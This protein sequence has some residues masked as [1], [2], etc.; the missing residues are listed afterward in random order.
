MSTY[1]IKITK[2]QPASSVHRK[3]LVENKE[4]PCISSGSTEPLRTSVQP[5]ISIL[6]PR[7]FTLHPGDSF[8]HLG[9][10]TP[11]VR[12]WP[13]LISQGCLHFSLRSFLSLLWV[14]CSAWGL[15]ST[16]QP[17]GVLPSSLL[18]SIKRPLLFCIQPPLHLLVWGF[19]CPD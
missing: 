11:V 8:A 9:A 19:F 18:R 3:V 16:G 5:D 4:W 15:H 12:L 17:V 6:Q 14:F 2:I 1:C 13:L 10:S 7:V